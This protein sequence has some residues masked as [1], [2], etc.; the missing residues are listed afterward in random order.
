MDP[1]PK[2][3]ICEIS[4]ILKHIYS[5]FAIS[6]FSDVV[7]KVRFL[8]CHTVEFLLFVYHDFYIPS[9]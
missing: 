4:A 9:H 6:T 7:Y 5:A 2:C 3:E 8:V 1:L